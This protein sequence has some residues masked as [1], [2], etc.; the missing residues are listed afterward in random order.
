M[1]LNLAALH[2][3]GEELHEEL[4]EGE[5]AFSVESVTL[6]AQQHEASP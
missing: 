4:K 5:P 3:S 6:G 1:V 2:D